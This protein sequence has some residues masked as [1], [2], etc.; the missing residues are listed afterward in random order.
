MI[1]LATAAFVAR[2]LNLTSC[3]EA[4][5]PTTRRSMV[6]LMI[7][8]NFFHSLVGRVHRQIF[9]YF[10]NYAPMRRIQ[11]TILVDQRARKLVLYGELTASFYENYHFVTTIWDTKPKHNIYERIEHRC[12]NN[13]SKMQSENVGFFITPVLQFMT[14]NRYKLCCLS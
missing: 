14:F 6:Q 11:R 10:K 5:R 12:N 4:N 7:L 8:L 9:C 13:W 3:F 2:N 1:S